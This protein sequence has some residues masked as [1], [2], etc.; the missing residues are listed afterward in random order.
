MDSLGRGGPPTEIPDPGSLTL[1]YDEIA[2]GEVVGQG[3]NADVFR[4]AVRRNR[5]EIPVAV[6][7]PRLQGTLDTDTVD[8]FVREADVW[9]ELDDHDHIV[10]LYDW[11][12]E[13]LPW[14]AME[15]MDR[16]TLAD[17]PDGVRLPLEQ[18]LWVG[19]CVC[20]AVH[21]A[22]RFGVAHHDLTSSTS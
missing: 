3:G 17:V 5:R 10:S 18:A 2:D 19:V 9:A 13:P 12:T 7:Q 21:H 8:R 22:H 1:S 20:R 6:K 14:L 4:V 15:Y 16:G 11:G